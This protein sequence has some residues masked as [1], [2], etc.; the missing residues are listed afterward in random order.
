MANDSGLSIERLRGRGEGRMSTQSRDLLSRV[1]RIVANFGLDSAMW[2]EAVS[3][4]HFLMTLA[5]ELGLNN[6][7]D[8]IKL[9]EL[10]LQSFRIKYDDSIELEHNRILITPQETEKMIA[11]M[12]QQDETSS[13]KNLG[14]RMRA[15]NIDAGQMHLNYHYALMLRMA[16]M[17]DTNYSR[18]IRSICLQELE[19]SSALDP[20]GGWYPYRTPWLTAR[21]II[22]LTESSESVKRRTGA[23]VNRAAD[24]LWDRAAPEGWES[25]AGDWVSNQ[26]S[27][28]LCLEA[29]MASDHIWDKADFAKRIIKE[30]YIRLSAQDSTTFS[31]E[32]EESSN[33]ALAAC[34]MASV[35]LRVQLQCSEDIVDIACCM[36]IF[37][38]MLSLTQ[39]TKNPHNR[40]FC[41][42]PQVLYYITRALKVY[43]EV[44]KT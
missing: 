13:G 2:S 39:K 32:T 18:A 43:E 19:S 29:L 44:E 24:S 11:S 3:G 26:E 33:D 38:S 35:L 1:R 15:M 40:Q 5:H 28:A 42:V 6:Q 9:Y 12:S 17:R 36:R 37:E 31:F 16:S 25:G 20:Y 4:Q 30:S 34:I 7:A 10:F 21:V 41:T 27:T 23:L 22:T 14:D 8:Y